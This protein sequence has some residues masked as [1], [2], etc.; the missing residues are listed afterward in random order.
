MKLLASFLESSAKTPR[1]ALVVVQEPGFWTPRNDHAHVGGFDD[2]RNA[3]G[4]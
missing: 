4:F 3:L 1:M 2:H